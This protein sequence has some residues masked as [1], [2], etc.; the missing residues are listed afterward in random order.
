[1]TAPSTRP[2]GRVWHGRTSL[3][4]A[5]AYQE[6]LRNETLPGLRAIEGFEQAIVLRRVADQAAEF[7][8]FTL[9]ASQDA[10]HAFAGEDAERAV[11]P[12]A[13]AQV[14]SQWDE[15]ASHY[16]VALMIT[17]LPAAAPIIVPPSE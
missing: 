1:M 15:R 8:V 3:A 11:I 2:V 7:L 16:E 14:L 12:T 6:H 5:H 9:W 10:V 4:N 17:G 13:A